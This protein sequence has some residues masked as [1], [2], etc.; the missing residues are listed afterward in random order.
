M[1]D[2]ACNCYAKQDMRRSS[3]C[4]GKHA[5][6]LHEGTSMACGNNGKQ[7]VPPRAT[8]EQRIE[9]VSPQKEDVK[10]D[11]QMALGKVPLL[12]HC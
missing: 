11:L 4:H 10:A 3:R 8:A 6:R 9:S 1:C 2:V 12:L 5:R 7:E